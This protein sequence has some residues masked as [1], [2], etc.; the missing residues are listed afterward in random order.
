[1]IIRA[2][3][4]PVRDTRENWAAHPEFIPMKGELVIYTDYRTIMEPDGKVKLI[5]GIKV[6][7]GETS[8]ELLPFIGGDGS[9][10]VYYNELQGLPTINGTTI[11][12]NMT[13][14]DLGLQKAGNYPEKPLTAEDIDKI[15]DESDSE[16]TD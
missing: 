6:G 3:I 14:E 12:G 10:P 15:I 2:R 9:V 16:D 11:L 4:A 5:P 1:M 13:A 8:V 7:D